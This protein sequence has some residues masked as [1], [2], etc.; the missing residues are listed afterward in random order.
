MHQRI[1]PGLSGIDATQW[2]ALHDG[3][4]PFVSHAFL[5]G[6]EQTGCVSSQTGWAPCHIAIYADPGE[7]RLLGAAPLYLK[8]HS[9]GEYVF[10]WSWADAYRQLGYQYYPKL[11]SCVPFTPVTGP[12]LLTAPDEGPEAVAATKRKLIDQALQ[13][14]R[15]QETSSLHWLFT[16]AEDTRLLQDAEHMK[17]T[18]NQFHWH[19]NDYADFDEYLASLTSKRRKQIRRERRRVQDSGLVI[20]TRDGHE[21]KAAHW[22]AMFEFYRATVAGHGAYGYLNREFF[23]HLG[24]H[25]RDQVLLVLAREQSGEYAAGALFLRGPDALFGRYW[26]AR[27]HYDDLHFELCYYRPIEHCI[28]HR[29]LRF[30][31]G[32]QGEHKLSRG[33]LPTATFS[34]HWLAHGQFSVAVQRFLEHEERGVSNY[35]GM[36]AQHSPFRSHG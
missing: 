16:D 8:S 32:A 25:M 14:A 15:D 27:G 20:E 6:L 24:H 12:R 21:L 26:G 7:T 30:E 19:N 31:A 28:R 17:R 4:N 13:F 33:L 23:E 10:D 34:A 36:L 1:L 9:Y 2:D 35:A 18:G 3:R 29:L 22:D 11:V 5:D